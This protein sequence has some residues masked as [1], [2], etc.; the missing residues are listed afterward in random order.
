MGFVGASLFVGDLTLPTLA[1]ENLAVD[2]SPLNLTVYIHSPGQAS[3]VLG[4]FF[5][6]ATLGTVRLGGV[7]G[8]SGL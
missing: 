2:W 4:G 8:I 1:H 3:L 7:T 6:R 5:F